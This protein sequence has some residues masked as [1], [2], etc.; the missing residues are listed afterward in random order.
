M[1]KTISKTQLIKDVRLAK[2]ELEIVFHTSNF[3]I[4]GRGINNCFY[5]LNKI[6]KGSKKND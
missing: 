2:K 6:I 3:D 5:L 4:R 1:I